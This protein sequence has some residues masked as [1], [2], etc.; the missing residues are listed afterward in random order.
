MSIFVPWGRFL[1][2]Y[3]VSIG[4]AVGFVVVVVIVRQLYLAYCLAGEL[5][6]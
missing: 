6:R 3:L 1:R 4:I 5:A 2:G